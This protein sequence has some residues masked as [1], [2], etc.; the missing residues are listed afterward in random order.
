MKTEMWYIYAW[1]YKICFK[2][3]NRIT[4]NINYI[5]KMQGPVYL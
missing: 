1:G 4:G 2:F 5:D 3:I